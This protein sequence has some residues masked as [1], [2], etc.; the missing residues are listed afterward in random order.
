VATERV[1]TTTSGTLFT[2]WQEKLGSCL[3]LSTR[4]FTIKI[5]ASA[6]RAMINLKKITSSTGIA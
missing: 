3:E 1:S 4:P 6:T 2:H 5:V